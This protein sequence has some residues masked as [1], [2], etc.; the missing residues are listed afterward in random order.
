MTCFMHGRRVSQVGE[1]H[2]NKVR[3][4]AK[5]EEAYWQRALEGGWRKGNEEWVEMKTT[6]SKKL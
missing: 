2:I 3:R 4:V 6:Q 5:G 1:F